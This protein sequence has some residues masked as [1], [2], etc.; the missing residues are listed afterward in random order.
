MANNPS[1][2]EAASMEV[3]ETKLVNFAEK[4]QFDV[5]SEFSFPPL[6]PNGQLARALN[7]VGATIVYPEDISNIQNPDGTWNGSIPNYQFVKDDNLY[8]SIEDVPGA[9]ALDSAKVTKGLSEY[10]IDDVSRALVSHQGTG[11]VKVFQLDPN[12]LLTVSA[13]YKIL[14][15]RPH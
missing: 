12:Q 4:T 13:G 3:S 7:S 11:S 9:T 6:D 8:S 2:P 14:L 10:T 1:D 15:K 5:T